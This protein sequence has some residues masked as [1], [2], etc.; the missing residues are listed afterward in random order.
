[1]AESIAAGG[2]NSVD[3]A[4]TFGLLLERVA[5]GDR[6]AFHAFYDRFGARVMAVVRKQVTERGLAEDLVQEIF[7]AVWLSAAGYRQDL[8]NP[9]GWL[10]G[11]ARHKILDHCR[12]VC[13][14]AA[15]L[16]QAGDGGGPKTQMPDSDRRLSVEQA[17]V[18]LTEDQRCVIDLIYGAGLTFAEAARALK[19]PAGTVKSRVSA[20]L[21][22]LRA[23]FT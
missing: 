17:L 7:V 12:R 21:T 13:R 5:A 14:I 1:M 3:E 19:I 6:D 16:G 8:G 10:V 18:R 4:A 2:S 20:A 11:I 9:E 15:V 22:T 23:F